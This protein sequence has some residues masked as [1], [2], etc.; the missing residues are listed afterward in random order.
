[1]RLKKSI[2][3][4]LGAVITT[5][6]LS[7]CTSHR[8]GS[9]ESNLVLDT[10]VHRGFFYADP[11]DT[12]SAS[13]EVSI[14]F[15]YPLNHPKLYGELVHTTFP[16]DIVA[17]YQDA[18]TPNLIAEAYFKRLGEDFRLETPNDTDATQ[19][20]NSEYLEESDRWVMS[21]ENQFAYQDDHVA[22]FAT[23]HYSYTGGAHGYESKALISFDKV[24]GK[25]I[26]EVDIFVQG[27]EEPLAEMIKYQL[28]QT[29]EVAS[30]EEL[31]QVGFFNPSEI[32]PNG[33]FY[34]LDDALIYCFNPY[35]I[36]PYSTGR[37]EVR[38][39]YEV[40][41]SIAREDGK[42]AHYLN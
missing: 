1:M 3:A 39:P 4:L 5:C 28:Q 7:Q 26:T 9:T 29:Y 40:V 8:E 32:T 31:E 14:Q 6:S 27:Y 30:A 2:I 41:R 34:L 38:I 20:E 17:T 16:E 18:T 21:L 42:L 10:L 37:I 19:E 23:I 24:T 13:M 22:S 12:T 36:A 15:I 11:S 35:E 25:P 33:N